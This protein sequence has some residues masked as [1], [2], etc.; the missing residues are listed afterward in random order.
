MYR[1]IRKSMKPFIAFS[2]VSMLGAVSV[3]FMAYIINLLVE[4]IT[5]GKFENF[6]WIAVLSFVYVLIDSYLDYA[7]DVVNERL[8]QEWNPLIYQ[9]F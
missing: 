7:V 3:V 8:T 2:F 6:I 9:C 1:Y 4:T 5:E